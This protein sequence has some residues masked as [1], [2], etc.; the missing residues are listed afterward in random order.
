MLIGILY[1]L[2][3]CLPGDIE[4]SIDTG[5]SVDI[6]ELPSSRNT[7]SYFDSVRSLVTQFEWLLCEGRIVIDGA[8]NESF[9]FLKILR[10][11]ELKIS[12]STQTNA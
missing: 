2:L 1:C 10:C 8:I 5:L 4:Q 3:V 6:S 11:T 7:V 9:G 12:T